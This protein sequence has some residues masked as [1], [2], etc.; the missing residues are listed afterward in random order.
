[1]SEDE[2]DVTC[3]VESFF[4]NI[5]INET[6][7]FICDE[8]NIDKKFQPICKRSIFKKRLLK[9]TTECTFVTKSCK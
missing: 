2:E 7:D 1:M 8:I 9:L 5:P 3:D 6:I 4:T